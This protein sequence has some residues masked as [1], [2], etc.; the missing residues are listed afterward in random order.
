MAQ[1]ESVQVQLLDT[2]MVLRILGDRDGRLVVN[3]ERGATTDLVAKL[4]KQIAQ[5]LEFSTCCNSSNVL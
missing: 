3:H 2:A 4:C 5:P 1:P